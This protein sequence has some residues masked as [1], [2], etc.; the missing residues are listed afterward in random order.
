MTSGRFKG[1]KRRCRTSGTE[2]LSCR[3]ELHEQASAYA[4]EAPESGRSAFP[5]HG[6]L[7]GSRERATFWIAGLSHEQ[8][9]RGRAPDVRYDDREHRDD[10]PDKLFG[11]VTTAPPCTT[12]ATVG[13]S[14]G[15]PDTIATMLL[16]R[17]LDELI[18]RIPKT[19]ISCGVH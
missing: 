8:P 12:A 4:A 10:L 11:R 17:C 9:I 3:C 13:Q 16:R 6:H 14:I 19:R 5:H 2:A 15:R 7:P 1:V 18:H